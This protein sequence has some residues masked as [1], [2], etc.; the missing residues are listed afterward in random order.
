MK[1][2]RGLRDVLKR[3]SSPLTLRCFHLAW[4][5]S[6][7]C[8]PLSGVWV[9]AVFWTDA[10]QPEMFVHPAFE[11]RRSEGLRGD[12]WAGCQPCLLTMIYER[13]RG[14]QRQVM[15]MESDWVSYCKHSVWH[16]MKAHTGIHYT[17]SHSAL[18]DIARET[19]SFPDQK[20][21][22]QRT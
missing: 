6:H 15:V 14:E 1:E 10:T 16:L 11:L 8:C 4:A 22:G 13:S 21:R 7:S 9:S 18:Y 2:E 17:R 12:V 19:V 20:K 3:K 5:E